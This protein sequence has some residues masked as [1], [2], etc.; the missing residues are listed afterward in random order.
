MKHKIEQTVKVYL[1]WDDENNEWVIDPIT[2]DGSELDGST[3][4]VV[5]N[6]GDH[7]DH[8]D[9]DNDVCEAEAVRAGLADLPNARELLHML[10]E[11]FGYGVLLDGRAA[12]GGK[13]TRAGDGELG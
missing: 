5:I 11:W 13:F 4:G 3:D 8:E 9:V 10:A 6:C 7:D 2:C 12:V 1:L